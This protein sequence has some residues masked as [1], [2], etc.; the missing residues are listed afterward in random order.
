MVRVRVAAHA[1]DL[2]LQRMRLPAEAEFVARRLDVQRALAPAQIVDAHRKQSDIIR[3]GILAGQLH[4]K[5][6]I[7]NIRTRRIRIAA[8]CAQARQ[9]VGIHVH[10]CAEA[11][12]SA[13][14]NRRGY[15]P[16]A[17]A[18]VGHR[19]SDAGHAGTVIA[20][21]LKVIERI[22]HR[23]AGGEFVAKIK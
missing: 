9:Q 13:Q 20:K 8:A 23:R 22:G 21:D 7:E 4:A 17:R 16:P 1:A 6:H 15:P 12:K 11:T 19:T 3:F 5:A 10:V 18:V 2:G 14:L